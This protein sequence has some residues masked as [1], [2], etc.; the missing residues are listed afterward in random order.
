MSFF[1]PPQK[2]VRPCETKGELANHTGYVIGRDCSFCLAGYSEYKK[3]KNEI[4]NLKIVPQIPA[5]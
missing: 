4:A 2:E 5:I 1:L 3:H